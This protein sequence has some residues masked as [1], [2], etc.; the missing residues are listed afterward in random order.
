LVRRMMF[1]ISAGDEAAEEVAPPAE[2]AE[3]A[4]RGVNVEERGA[5]PKASGESN[6]G[7]KKRRKKKPP[8]TWCSICG[9][10]AVVIVLTSRRISLM[11]LRGD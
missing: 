10:A 6:A 8:T 11:Q 9:K 3:A 5:K 1:L 7:H 4:E 2:V